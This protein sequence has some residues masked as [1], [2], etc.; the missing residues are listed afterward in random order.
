[1]KLT[2]LS[3]NELL[4]RCAWCRKKMPEDKECFGAGARVTKEAKKLLAGREGQLVP[5]CLKSGR[6]VIVIVPGAGST[7][8]AEGHDI[9]FQTCSDLCCKELSQALNTE[10]KERA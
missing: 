7:A 4:R 1:M 5:M 6:E 2:G 9:Y 8:A 10:L 3:H